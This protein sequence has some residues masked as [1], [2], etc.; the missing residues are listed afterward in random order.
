MKSTIIIMAKLPTAGTVKTRLHS[1]FSPE[2]CAALARAFLLD[3][4]AK[5]Q[6]VCK[7]VILAYAPAGERELL[8]NMVSPRIVLVEQIGENLGERMAQAFEFACAADSAVVMIGTDSTT[9]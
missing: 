2:K 1:V 8:E 3:T 9:L 5:A 7:N 6:T 4:I